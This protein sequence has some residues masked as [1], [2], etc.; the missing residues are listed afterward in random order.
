[1]NN[2]TCGE[3]LY[4][5]EPLCDYKAM[6]VAST[7]KCCNLFDPKEPPMT[8]GDK[9]IAGGSVALA[10]FKRKHKCD[11]CVYML[12]GNCTEPVDKKDRC[13]LGLESWLNAPA[14]RGTDNE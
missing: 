11:C 6:K 8:N 4:Y 5:D 3:C 12:G 14:E 10:A 7:R 9:I 13:E 2:K 1:M